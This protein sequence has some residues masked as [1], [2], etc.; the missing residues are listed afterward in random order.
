M[1]DLRLLWAEAARLYDEPSNGLRAASQAAVLRG[2]EG[3][4]GWMRSAM[5]VVRGSAPMGRARFGWLG[6]RK[7]GCAC[8]ASLLVLA[9]LWQ[10]GALAVLAAILAFYAVE[11][12]L[13]FVFPLALDGEQAPFAAS[14]QLAGRSLQPGV[15]TARVMT[16]AARMVFGGIAKGEF[17]RSWCVGCLA[18]VLWYEDARRSAR[19]P[20]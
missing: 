4:A 13:L 2:F 11:A 12:R 7:Y 5:G 20:E 16:I 15:A 19:T 8:L 1:R 6:V 9:A 3:G 18:V 17:L 10:L 14:R